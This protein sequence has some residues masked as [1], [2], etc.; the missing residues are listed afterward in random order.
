M[1]DFAAKA[2]YIES[3]SKEGKFLGLPDL[4]VLAS[5]FDAAVV[6][7]HW[8]NDSAGIPTLIPLNHTLHSLSGGVWTE[9]AS[10]AVDW[11]SSKT[12]VVAFVHATYERAE[13]SNLNHALPLF[14]RQQLGDQW[15]SLTEALRHKQS[16]RVAKLKKRLSELSGDSD[17]ELEAS[18]QDRLDTTLRKQT[19][20]DLM[21]DMNFYPVDV[22]ADGNCV[23]WSVMTLRRGTTMLHQM[24]TK[25]SVK[26][27]RAVPKQFCF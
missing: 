8:T 23:L 16:E 5:Q 15:G 1:R 21:M 24:A 11:E 14:A 18:L 17:G 2:G 6:T 13:F 26:N 10:A 7:T 25:E 22:P 27:C 19:F 4:A 12:W 3:H 9:D 20:F